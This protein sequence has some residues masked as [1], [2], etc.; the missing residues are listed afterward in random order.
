[1]EAEFCRDSSLLAY[2]VTK[3]AGLSWSS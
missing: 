1:M 2:T 3:E